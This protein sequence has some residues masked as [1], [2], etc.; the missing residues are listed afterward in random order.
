MFKLV[1]YGSKYDINREPNNGRGPVDYK[2]SYG[3]IDTSLIEFKL[4]K[5]TKLKQNLKNQ[6]E[7]Y[8]KS[9]NTSNG[10]KVILFFTEDEEIRAKKIIKE[11]DMEDDNNII[12]IDA[13]KDNK[14]SASNVK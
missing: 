12:L 2:F 5:S 4:A 13:R 10:L 7:I 11:L 9:N 6:L 14:L 8:K 1:C 3:A